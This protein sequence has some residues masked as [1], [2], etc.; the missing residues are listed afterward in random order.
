MIIPG[1]ANSCGSVPGGLDR[2]MDG[3]ELG[4][5]TRAD[6]GGRELGVAEHLAG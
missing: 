1:L 3:A 2:G 4:E 6:P 5:A